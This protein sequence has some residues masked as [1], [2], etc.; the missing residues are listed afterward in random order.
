MERLLLFL[1]LLIFGG[2]VKAQVAQPKMQLSATEH[3]FGTFKEE[4]GRQTFDFIVTNTGNDPLVIQN[5]VASC[6][7]TTP[8]WTKQP[9]PAGGKGKVTAIYDPKD[10]PGV[11]SK[12]LSVYSNSKPEVVILVIK[13]EVTPHEKTIE[14]LFTF[15]A[16]TV[17]FESQ[18]LAFTNVKKT[19]K[20]IRVMQLINTS[21][22]P[23]KVEFD[24]L[25]GHLSLK[26]NPETLKPGQKGLV[27][28]TYDATK[29]PVW[30]N[31]TDMVKVKLDGV[32]QQNV[33]YYVSAN[34]VEDFSSLS[35]E[36]MANAPV[37]K[38]STTT[39]ELGKIKGST[40][41]EVEF[42]FINEGKSD[43]II[44]YIRSTCGCTAVQQGNQGIGIKPGESSSIK[45]V[46]N[47]G[48]Y[49]GKVTKAIY[50]YTN[51]PK[52]SEVVLM[53]NADVEQP[54]VAK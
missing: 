45:A 53:L 30:G 16:G 7:C 27:E 33:Y 23:V 19:E 38:V 42:K 18:N 41:N 9:I 36:D 25:P 47:S 1:T 2:I 28:G 11:F 12:T 29:N 10:R 40:Q 5:V 43:L 8:E 51:D 31:V 26:A 13:G 35:N 6:G 37:F 46:F 49:V 22:A 32:I 39:F 21:T 15:A 4:A 14:E 34:L 50:V 48:G 52:N 24:G 17:R 3:D 44:R 54:P 20:K